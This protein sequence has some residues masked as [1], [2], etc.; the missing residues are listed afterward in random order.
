M[1]II[2]DLSV[3]VNTFDMIRYCAQKRIHFITTSVE[4]WQPT[5][6]MQ[7]KESIAYD[8]IELQKIK[9]EIPIDNTMVINSG[10]NLDVFPISLEYY[11]ITSLR[12]KNPILKKQRI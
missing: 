12:V 11:L 2:I 6:E 4:P 10:M 7:S 5:S 9:N 8:M 3:Y 1:D